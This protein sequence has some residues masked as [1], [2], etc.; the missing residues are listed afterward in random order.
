MNRPL[1]PSDN[2]D[3]N[4]NKT[5]YRDQINK[6]ALS[7]REIISGLKV[8]PDIAPDKK[9]ENQLS[10][11]PVEEKEVFKEGAIDK[12]KVKPRKNVK[13]GILIGSLLINII[14]VLIVISP[15]KHVPFSEKDGW[16]LITDF[17]NMTG[18][19]IFDLS[20]N[21][22]LEVSIQQSSFVNVFPPDRINETPK[23]D[24]KGKH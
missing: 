24:G 12:E 17:E 4:L 10:C 14:I 13:R 21:K 16:I 5:Y 11:S 22:A 1:N 20:L 2:P 19:S 15:L 9:R 7:I 6:V 3:K 23:K 18:D 8:E